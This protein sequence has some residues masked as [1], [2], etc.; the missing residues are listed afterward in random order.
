MAISVIIGGVTYSAPENGERSWGSN[1]TDLLVALSNLSGRIDGLNPNILSADASFTGVYGLIANYLTSHTANP[2]LAGLVRAAKTDTIS[3][4]NNAN[5]DNVVLGI[6]A[7]DALQIDGVDLSLSTDLTTHEADTSTH[8][9]GVV[10]GLDETQTFT[11]KTLTSPKLNEDV[12]VSATATEV[13]ILDGAT[14]STTELN[15]SD[16]VTSDIQTQIDAKVGSTDFS[17]APSTVLTVDPGGAVAPSGTISTTELDTL[18]NISSNIQ[19]QLDTADSKADE[20]DTNCNDIITTV[21]V[22]ENATDMGTY[23]GSTI[24]DNEKA[25]ENIQELETAL[26]AHEDIVAGNPHVVTATEVGLGNVDNTSDATKNAATATL[27]NKTLTSIKGIEYNAGTYGGLL[28]DNSIPI[29]SPIMGFGNPG[30]TSFGGLI[31]GSNN[32]A[33]FLVNTT[34]TAVAV[35]HED[36]TTTTAANRIN[37]GTGV[38]IEIA[39]DACLHIIYD[40]VSSRWIVAG[41]T[42]SGSGGLELES[43]DNTDS[44]VTAEISKH[45]LCDVSTASITVNLPAGADGSSIRFSDATGDM[46]LTNVVTLN[47]AA[48]ETINGYAA[49]EDLVLDVGN[50]WVQLNW[51]TDNSVW[52]VDDQYGATTV[53]GGLT[54]VIKTANFVAENNKH[55]LCDT[56]SAAITVTLPS[57]ADLTK[58]RFSDLDKNFGTNNLIIETAGAETI[59]EKTSYTLR[60]DGAWIQIMGDAAS[61]NW[62]VDKNVIAGNGAIVGPTEDV[63]FAGIPSQFNQVAKRWID[64]EWAHY[65][66]R[67]EATSESTATSVTLTLP[68]GDVIDTDSILADADSGVTSV[69]NAGGS[70]KPGATTGTNGSSNPIDIIYQSSSTV[71]VAFIREIAGSGTAHLNSQLAIPSSDSPYDFDTGSTIYAYF[72]LPLVRLKGTGTTNLNADAI[73]QTK[74][75]D[76]T[77]LQI[78]GTGIT[79]QSFAT[80]RA[81]ADSNDQWYL[82]FKADIKTSDATLKTTQAFTIDGVSAATGLK[83]DFNIS[84]RQVA[85]RAA[86]QFMYGRTEGGNTFSL[87]A[88]STINFALNNLLVG[89]LIKLDGP[90]T[91]A[92][93]NLEKNP[94]VGVEGSRWQKRKLTTDVTTTTAN[95][96][97][98]GFAYLTIGKKYRVTMQSVFVATTSNSP[99][100]GLFEASHNSAVIARATARTDTYGARRDFGYDVGTIFKATAT[101]LVFNATLGG[102]TELKGDNTFG[103]TWVMLEELALYDDETTA[104]TP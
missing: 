36:A 62:V 93:A 24:T 25:K 42:G 83:Q 66:V 41:G 31:S 11:A 30:I 98:L 80:G 86:D 35:K 65:Q 51:D 2:A 52:V 32:K 18:N 3:W 45:Y 71:R 44:P 69:P 85:A 91:W 104:F 76:D 43:I 54:T 78:G 61:T 96:S 79:V 99:D 94:A 53:G 82:D 12:V 33:V 27:D 57:V 70:M 49:D 28:S 7:T 40:I 47:P 26:E 39:D 6:S 77:V 34:G 37:T 48:G 63:T 14:L 58:I 20:I 72:S 56:T 84:D 60:D 75:V 92:A 29:S 100:F 13:N 38:D 87:A 8:G 21:G 68:T 16:G 95:I 19:D 103:E 17:G 89:G 46:S 15:Y 5:T 97:D 88:S 59:D 74:W 4:R 64:G 73:K 1:T 90:P 55:Y 9:V 101:T 10:A 102:S 81:F 23:T 50:A 67:L 22:A